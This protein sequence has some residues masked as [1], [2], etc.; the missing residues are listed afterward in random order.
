[1]AGA[2]LLVLG[3][4][5][6]AWWWRRI[7]GQAAA[8]FAMA[9][10]VLLPD[11]WPQ[12][13][14]PVSLTPIAVTLVF[15]AGA[16]ELRRVLGGAHRAAPLPA[17]APAGSRPARC[18]ARTG[19]GGRPWGRSMAAP[20]RAPGEGRLVLRSGPSRGARLAEITP[21]NL[22]WVM[23]AKGGPQCRWRAATIATSDSGGGAG[24]Q[25]D[26]KAFA[27]A[28]CHGMSALVALTAQSTVG[29]RAIHELPA[30]FI[31]AQLDA[32]AD[33]I[34]VDAAKTGMLFSTPII[35]AVA[36]WLAPTRLPTRRRPGDGGVIGGACC[37]AR[38]P[39]PPWC[40]RLFPRATVIT[41]NLPEARG[42]DRPPRA[43]ARELAERLHEMGAAAVLVTGGH[44]ESARSTTSSTASEHHEIPV[45]RHRVAGHPRRRLHPFGHPLRPARSATTCSRAAR[46]AARVAADAVAAWLVEIGR[47]DGPVN[48]LHRAFTAPASPTRRVP[49]SPL[50]E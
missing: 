50:P 43:A 22:I 25:A 5:G 34:G 11:I 17:A 6:W 47:G 46:T 3:F 4:A 23:P 12:H 21:E 10:V 38:T 31:T 41:P 40:D 15:S 18:N 28:G 33:D 27:A 26:L 37:S 19:V 24:M 30:D 42:A 14:V 49:R 39:S 36:G 35:E 44:G 48:V 29:V 7:T 13:V 16:L 8:S 20:C 45:V 2:V 1:M 9:A 32:V